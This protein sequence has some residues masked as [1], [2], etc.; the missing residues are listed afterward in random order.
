MVFEE[1]SESIKLEDHDKE[2][3]SLLDDQ[4]LIKPHGNIFHPSK[5]LLKYIIL[6]FVC[7]T[8][9]G[10]YYSYD[11][12]AVIATEILYVSENF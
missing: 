7:S 4:E 5:P 6:F 11:S 8:I 10:S 9:L 2:Y 3:T 1:E 12:I